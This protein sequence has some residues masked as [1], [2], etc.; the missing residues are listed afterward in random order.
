MA[1]KNTK[2]KTNNTKTAKKET[3]A[4]IKS[5]TALAKNKETSKA[6][7]TTNK[8]DKEPKN[9]KLAKTTTS[10]KSA[11]KK[12]SSSL[13][14][15]TTSKKAGVKTTTK[16]K[17]ATK[18]ASKSTSS[19]SK[20]TTSKVNTKK[21][22]DKVLE[23]YDLPF[24]YNKTLVKILAQT[25]N[26]LFVYWEI[27]DEDR[28]NFIKQYGENFF[29]NTR[30]VLIVHNKTKNYSFEIEI[31]DFANS[32]YF[33]VNDSKCEY[34]IELG[35]R[36]NSYTNVIPNNYI[37]IAYSNKIEAPN[38]HILFE[39]GQ[40][41]IFFRNTKTNHTYS[42]DIINLQFINHFGKAYKIYNFYDKI[43]NFED[44]NTISNPT[45]N[46]TNI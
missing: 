19:S 5:A 9:T 15:S 41:T 28:N 17:T 29:T 6:K 14:K 38:D 7:K 22:L 13:P 24:T 1:E 44:L 26:T 33:N 34:E 10:T 31:N 21:A 18:K 27:S 46:F 30:P 11:E 20:E 42:K 8:T 12:T 23:Y 2:K 4:P 45:S 3:K 43:Y 35:R 16:S 37:G 39:K 25:P 36:T 40:N 32:W